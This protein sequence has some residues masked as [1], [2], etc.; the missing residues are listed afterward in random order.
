MIWRDLYRRMLCAK[1]GSNNKSNK[2]TT[3]LKFW[4]TSIRNMTMPIFIHMISSWAEIQAP[5]KSIN[6]GRTRWCGTTFWLETCTRFLNAKSGSS[7]S[8]MAQLVLRILKMLAIRLPT[9]WFRD[10][11]GTMLALDTCAEVSI[12][13][14]DRL[15]S[16][17]LSRFCT[18]N[19]LASM[20]QRR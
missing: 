8:S 18:E 10:A 15:I 13:R 1:F 14:E 4:I 5:S 19:V 2:C 3:T 6:H 9:C 7:Q 20:I 11:A 12:R 16:S 17:K